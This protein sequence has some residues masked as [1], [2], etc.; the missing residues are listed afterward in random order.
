MDFVEDIRVGKEGTKARFGAEKNRPPAISGARIVLRVG[1][2]E[3]PSAQ[4]DELFVF[5]RF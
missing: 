5:P 2:A 4:R 3:D 1:V